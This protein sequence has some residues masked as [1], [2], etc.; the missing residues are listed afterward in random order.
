MGQGIYRCALTV[1]LALFCCAAH[2]IQ[3]NE[4]R[5]DQPGTDLDEYFELIG[6]P[7]ESLDGLSY[8]VIGDGASGGSGVIEV[9]ISLDDLSIPDDGFFLAAEQTFSLKGAIPDLITSLNFENG[10]NLTHLLVSGLDEG[11]L[12]TDF[13][14]EPDDGI[15]DAMPWGS[16]LDAIGMIESLDPPTAGE[17]FYGAS[18]GFID[19]GP[20]GGFVPSHIFRSADEDSSWVMGE[21][22]PANIVASDTPGESNTGEVMMPDP[23]CDLDFNGMC[24]VD[25]LGL[26]TGIGDLDVGVESGFPVFYDINGDNRVDLLD[27]D[28]WLLIAAEESGFSSTYLLGDANLDGTVDVQDLN[29][30]GLNWLQADKEW[31]DGNFNGDGIVNVEDLNKIGL[32]WLQSVSSSPAAAAV[33][34]PAALVM[35]IQLVFLGG[36]VRRQRMAR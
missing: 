18:L 36:L 31:S 29:A 16:V 1:L 11:I 32:N 35:L 17:F 24:D 4:I 28:E 20:S 23:A 5:I 3:I 9:E 12:G 30:V 7:G 19:I 26:L 2:A 8:L 21:F 33:P 14:I 25:D 6:E 27:V 15:L 22:D 13:D 10:D 34:E